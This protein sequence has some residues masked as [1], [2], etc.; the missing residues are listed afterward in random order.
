MG[1]IL[2]AGSLG[3]GF[4]RTLSRPET[5]IVFLAIIYNHPIGIT[6]VVGSLDIDVRYPIVNGL[7]SELYE[8]VVPKMGL[9]I[10]YSEQ[11]RSPRDKISKIDGLGND[12]AGSSTGRLY[13]YFVV[14]FQ[15]PSAVEYFRIG[16]SV[17]DLRPF[18]RIGSQYVDV[19]K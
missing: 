11:S 9:E 19:E 16:N 10:R 2:S 17:P 18:N 13:R 15:R 6:H 4:V 5:P 3:F 8:R 12:V 7:G 1:T 14:S